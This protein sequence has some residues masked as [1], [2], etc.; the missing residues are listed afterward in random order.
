MDRY[1]LNETRSTTFSPGCRLTAT[2]KG[3]LV[4][5]LLSACSL[6]QA[7]IPVKDLRI[8]LPRSYARDA[9][10]CRMG[11]NA[12]SIAKNQR[13]GKKKGKGGGGGDKGQP[14]G[15]CLEIM[16]VEKS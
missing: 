2:M 4:T 10:V 13:G 15:A 12:A 6:G 9:G 1:D 5:T 16:A 11:L 8:T 7:F 14:K 3:L